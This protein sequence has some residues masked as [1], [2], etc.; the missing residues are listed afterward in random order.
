MSSTSLELGEIVNTEVREPSGAVTSFSHDYPIDGSRLLRIPSLSP[1]LAEGKTLTPELR[2]EIRD[3]FVADGVFSSV[4]VNLTLM[5]TRVDF[6]NKIQPGETLFLRLLG[7]D[8][9]VDPSS[10]S[11][12]VDGSGSINIPF[13]GGVLVRD[14][15]LFEV[16]HQIEQGL[17][18]AGAFAEPLVNVTRVQLA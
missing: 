12:A 18:D 4:T 9:T 6:E 1:I 5:S 7:L 16:E 14:S 10:G 8:G 2:D 13:L 15:F 3:R 17:I 11:F